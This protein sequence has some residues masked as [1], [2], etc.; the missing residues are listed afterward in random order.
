MN[1]PVHRRGVP[2]VPAALVQPK[3]NVPRGP[4]APV[5]IV[6]ARTRAS[7]G[8]VVPP[9]I[10]QQRVDAPRWP[11]APGAIGAAPRAATPPGAAASNVAQPSRFG[12]L[13]GGGLGASILGGVGL[14]AGA[15][16]TGPI[17]I[18]ALLVGSLV[19]GYIGH[20]VTS[21]VESAVVGG[22]QVVGTQLRHTITCTLSFGGTEQFTATVSEGKHCLQS[23]RDAEVTTPGSGMNTNTIAALTTI[24][25]RAAFLSWAQ[26]CA[27]ALVRK[28][29][30][31]NPSTLVHMTPQGVSFSSDSNG[32]TH[33]IHSFPVGGTVTVLTDAQ[34]ELLKLVG[35][36]YYGHG[37]RGAAA[38]NVRNILNQIGRNGDVAAVV[39]LL[40]ISRLQLENRV[41]QVVETLAWEREQDRWAQQFLRTVNW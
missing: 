24:Q 19:G 23:Y 29:T 25:F 41:D 9:A 35:R 38:A 11:V 12:A 7:R 17:G 13:V 20:S 14:Y 1:G 32:T 26:A 27:A 16:L 6:Q 31:W 18:G 39:N 40:G 3:A 21:N 22:L 4:V 34:Y 33:T 5:A 8:P 28:G 37:N 36:A 10:V 2:A 30:S 15:A